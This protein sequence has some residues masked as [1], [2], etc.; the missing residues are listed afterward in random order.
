MG[1]IELEKQTFNEETMSTELMSKAK[2]HWERHEKKFGKKIRDYFGSIVKYCKK[3]GNF[4]TTAIN[5]YQK[6][7]T[8]IE[9]HRKK[10]DEKLPSLQR[11]QKLR[12]MQD[13][14]ESLV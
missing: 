6:S 10:Q 14:F 4:T 8:K 3:K 1:K 7:F 13:G 11:K 12:K 2:Q 9:E 5:V